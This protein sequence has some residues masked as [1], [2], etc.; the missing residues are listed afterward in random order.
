[1]PDEEMNDLVK[2][3]ASKQS[4]NDNNKQTDSEGNLCEPVRDVLDEEPKLD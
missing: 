3:D 2:F 4:K 1:M